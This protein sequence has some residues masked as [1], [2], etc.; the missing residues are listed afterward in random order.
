[1]AENRFVRIILFHAEL[2]V[3][4]P[5]KVSLQKIQR[6]RIGERSL[7]MEIIGNQW[8]SMKIGQDRCGRGQGVQKRHKIKMYVNEDQKHKNQEK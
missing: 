5:N 2:V 8:K 6:T 1:M 4:V 7:Q 3:T